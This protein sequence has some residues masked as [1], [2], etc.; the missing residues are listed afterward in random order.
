MG[1][2]KLQWRGSELPLVYI[3]NAFYKRNYGRL[4][5]RVLVEGNITSFYLTHKGLSQAYEIGKKLLDDL[6]FEKV[7]SD[8]KELNKKLLQTVI[9]EQDIQ[10]LSF[11]GKLEFLKTV[12][13]IIDSVNRMYV[14]CEHSTLKA[15][16]D[17]VIAECGDYGNCA[18]LLT[19]NSPLNTLSEKT[20]NVIRKLRKIG[21][22]KLKIHENF[23]PWH[24]A[25]DNITK[26]IAKKH[27]LSV[28]QAQSMTSVEYSEAVLEDNIPSVKVL[29]TRLKGCALIPGSK[30]EYEILVNDDYVSWKKKLEG[31]LPRRVVGLTAYPG[32][33]TGRVFT[34]TNWMSISDIPKDAIL[35][36]G[37]TNPQLVPYLK[38]VRAELRVAPFL[39]YYIGQHLLHEKDL[40]YSDI[41]Q[42]LFQTWYFPMLFR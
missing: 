5:F 37:N 21:D 22:I 28:T 6:Y 18:M 14:Y 8:I 34:H 16:D 4:D 41:F 24:N 13:D 30:E 9:L 35:V 36:V 25:Q 29:N 1:E 2:Y 10:K 19:K 7:Y 27:D 42:A 40:C 15:L 20:K 38:N 26:M 32:K 3:S 23:E 11:S 17:V 12:D 39:Q 31:S 33:T